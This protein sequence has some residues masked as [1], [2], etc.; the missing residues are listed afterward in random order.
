MDKDSKLIFEAYKSSQHQVLN[1]FAPALVLAGGGVSALNVVLGVAAAAAGAVGLTWLAQKIGS[2]I[3]SGS[4]GAAAIQEK[5]ELVAFANSVKDFDQAIQSQD[6]GAVQ[7][8]ILQCGLTLANFKTP[9]LNAISKNLI[10]ATQAESEEAFD[11]AIVRSAEILRNELAKGGP[12]LAPA[13]KELDN[14]VQMSK[15]II[16]GPGYSGGK[17]SKG[18]GGSRGKGPTGPAK[19]PQGPRWWEKAG[20]AAGKFFE[21]VSLKG[22]KGVVYTIS[23]MAGLYAIIGIGSKLYSITNKALDKVDR[24]VGDAGTVVTDTTGTVAGATSTTREV[25]E[26]LF[27]WIKHATDKIP[28]PGQGQQKPPSAVPKPTPIVLTPDTSSGTPPS[29][30]SNNYSVEVPE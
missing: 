5:P 9:T 19:P 18:G 16:P 15:K 20:E 1:E 29:S 11:Q 23:T 3:T 7:N 17:G 28:D 6:I 26:K 13:V 14:I 21:G 27:G 24:A 25:L 2:G 30:S 10:A 12:E 8:A 22:C 4:T